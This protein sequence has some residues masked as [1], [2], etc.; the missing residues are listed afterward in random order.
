MPFAPTTNFA[1]PLHSSHMINPFGSLTDASAL[2][3]N[4]QGRITESQRNLLHITSGLTFWYAFGS[5][6][7]IGGI[8]VFALK[9]QTGQQYANAPS[10]PLYGWLVLAAAIGTPLV[11]LGWQMARSSRVR[12]ELS[13]NGI[14]SEEA[15]VVWTGRRYRVQA[16]VMGLSSIYGP[17]DL[18]PG[19][20]RLFLLP[21]SRYLLSAE[22]L[23]DKET[24]RKNM[25]AVFASRFHFSEE[26]LK[27]NREG[28]MTDAQAERLRRKAG[29]VLAEAA[30]ISLAFFLPLALWLFGGSNV[31]ALFTILGLG[32]CILIFPTMVRH[33]LNLRKDTDE[34]KTESVEGLGEKDYSYI[35]TGKSTV[36]YYIVNGKRFDVSGRNYGALID[37]KRYRVVYAAKS[38]V[39]LSM[40]LA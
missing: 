25:Q 14:P 37:G 31:W 29:G 7:G 24:M 18:V 3:T 40:E 6:L 34:R 36:S 8:T 21:G 38:Q 28:K 16:S 5:A 20:Y 30:F 13:Q 11:Y 26:D 19:R 23:D 4:Q 33:V 22:C 15:E 1:L 10:M 39:I 9:Q 35:L 17:L 27:A 2:A 32:V 12:R